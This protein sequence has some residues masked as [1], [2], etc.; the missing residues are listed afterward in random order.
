MFGLE[1]MAQAV[2][3]VAGESR[4]D[5]PRVENVRLE[6]PIAVGPEGTNIEIRAEVL[7]EDGGV[8]RVSAEIA[9]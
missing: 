5:S 6:R 7:E 8:R 9:V 2:A 1:A 3:C 4:L